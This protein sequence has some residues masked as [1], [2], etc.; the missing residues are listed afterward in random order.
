[1]KFTVMGCN[2]RRA[3]QLGL[4][5]K[6]L[7]I[8]EWMQ[9]FWP[10]MKKR[11]IEEKEYAW[12]NYRSLIQ[13]YPLMEITSTR[14]LYK[15]MKALQDIG[16]LDHRGIKDKTGSFSYYRI[17]EKILELIDDEYSRGGVPE[18]SDGGKNFGSDG[19]PESSYGVT[20]KVPTKDTSI[21][22]PSIIS[23][24]SNR[25]PFKPPT[26]EEV[27]KYC[28][29]NEINVVYERFHRYYEAGHWKDNKDKAI[30]NWKQKL[31]TWANDP[32]NYQKLVSSPVV[33][34][35]ISAD[36][37]SKIKKVRGD[38]KF[39]LG[40]SGNSYAV[41]FFTGPIEEREGI[42]IIKSSYKKALE[43]SHILDKINVK[44]II[45]ET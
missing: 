30:K 41:Q 18:S 1:M 7:A 14:G 36:E 45:N 33:A 21:I 2:Q 31:L 6:D 37:S 27:K 44:V 20:S 29:D 9:S 12:V 22:D 16:L 19:V 24:S 8:I 34:K 38:I 3:V 42:F 40:N 5:F 4:D 11:I 15:R 17:T 43:Y 26:L 23:S 28:F 32:K 10:K 39:A 35:I 25:K 13:D